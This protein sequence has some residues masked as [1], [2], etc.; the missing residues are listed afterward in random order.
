MGGVDIFI[1]SIGTG[2]TITGAGRFLKK[3]NRDI[4][5]YRFHLRDSLACMT[6]ILPLFLYTVY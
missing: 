4:K 2:G 6:S 5:V 3:M 1:A